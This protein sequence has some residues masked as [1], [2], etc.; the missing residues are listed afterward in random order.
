M[1][2]IYVRSGAQW[3]NHGEKP[4]KHFLNLEANNYTSKIIPKIQQENGETITK[5]EDILS[6]LN[7]IKVQKTC[8]TF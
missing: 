5:Q 2:G 4:S 3:L 6:S 1:Q 7:T 8:I